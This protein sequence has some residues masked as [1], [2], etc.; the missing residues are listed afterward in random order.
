MIRQQFGEADNLCKKFLAFASGT[1]STGNDPNTVA[2]TLR[3]L[4]DCMESDDPY[5][6]LDNSWAQFYATPAQWLYTKA[7][8]FCAL[9]N[10]GHSWVTPA[11]PENMMSALTYSP[12]TGGVYAWAEPDADGIY[13]RPAG[14]QSEHDV[15]IYGYVIGQYWK[16]FDSY[17]NETKKLAWDF[18][19][20]VV[21][22]YTLTKNI[23]NTPQAQ[24]AWQ[25]FLNFMSEIIHSLYDKNN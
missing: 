19:F 25:S 2:E 21:K 3:K 13:H 22:R 11:T 12:L 1:T 16:I 9:Y 8:E 20:D 15:C 7:L 4:G 10:F 18:G 24:S 23:V 5:T 14:A 6:S 17:A